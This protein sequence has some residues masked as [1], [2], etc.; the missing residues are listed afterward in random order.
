[1]TTP[2]TTDLRTMLDQ[3]TRDR[4]TPWRIEEQDD[5]YD[6][7]GRVVLPASDYPD[8]DHLIAAA[9]ELAA[10]VLRLRE[11]IE[12]L[13]DLAFSGA[14]VNTSFGHMRSN[15]LDLDARLRALLEDQ[16]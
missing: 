3:A 8:L 10:E 14:H 11:G 2:A 9:P 6:S 13:A 5:I 4:P 16:S 1:M 7:G 15:M 12:V